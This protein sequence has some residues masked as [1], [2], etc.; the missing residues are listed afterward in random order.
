MA[1]LVGLITGLDGNVDFSDIHI[2]TGKPV[3]LRVQGDIVMQD[4]IVSDEAVDHFL[5]QQLNE[6]Q[7][8]EL[9]DKRDID[10]AVTIGKKRYRL[11]IFHTLRGLAVSMRIIMDSLPSMEDLNMPWVVYDVLENRNGLILVTGA[12]GSGKSTSLAVMI[13]HLNKTR[14]G[15]ILTIEDPVEYIHSDQSCLVSQREVGRDAATF[16]SALRA[17]LREDPD[18]ILIG[19][20]RDQETIELALTAAE[21]G[22]LV[23]GTLHTS[24]APDTVNRIID[25]MPPEQHS[26]V[27]GQLSQCL[28]MVM[29]QQLLKRVDRPGRVAAFELM[30]GSSGIGNLIRENKVHQI[31]SVIQTSASAGML[32]LEKSKEQLQQ[33]GIIAQG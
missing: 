14:P 33:A 28:R 1:D 5:H 12:T 31:H 24:S 13:D 10:L 26:Q 8:L 17:A 7:W 11:N 16:Q 22:H 19:E 6:E 25:A 21:T 29:S 2:Q 15:H 32:L 30:L 18:I 3:S 9:R 23:F 20:M 27:R 4:E